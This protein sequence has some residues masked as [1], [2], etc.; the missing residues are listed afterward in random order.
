MT[1]QGRRGQAQ[2]AR[3]P[4]LCKPLDEFKY[5]GRRLD[6]NRC[7]HPARLLDVPV[8]A[9]REVHYSPHVKT[10]FWVDTCVENSPECGFIHNRNRFSCA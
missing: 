6:G 4:V 1:P 10:G 8:K 7:V 5:V 2:N 3:Q 9:A